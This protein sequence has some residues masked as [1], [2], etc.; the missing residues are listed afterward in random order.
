MVSKSGAPEPHFQLLLQ[1]GDKQLHTRSQRH[2]WLDCRMP[3]LG[4][5]HCPV[6]D[7]AA[8]RQRVFTESAHLL[9]ALRNGADTR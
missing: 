5:S 8:D 3:F 1:L 9:S 6:Y 7:L 2:T 4:T